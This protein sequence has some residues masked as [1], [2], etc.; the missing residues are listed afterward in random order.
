MLRYGIG[1]SIIG[2]GCSPLPEQAPVHLEAPYNHL[3]ASVRFLGCGND[4]KLEAATRQHGVFTFEC[5]VVLR[6]DLTAEAA[7]KEP[8]MLLR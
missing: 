8:E 5:H 1:S 2:P 4:L 3:S 7:V 6:Y